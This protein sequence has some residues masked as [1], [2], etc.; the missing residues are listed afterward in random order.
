MSKGFFI[1][2]EGGEGAGKSTV[3][4][5]L[6]EKLT[7]KG[8]TVIASREPGGCSLAEELRS[9]LLHQ[10]KPI[11]AKCELFLFLAARVQHIEEVIVPALDRGAIVLCDRFSD[12]TIAYQGCGKNLGFEYVQQVCKLAEGSCEPDCTLFLDI[13]PERGLKRTDTRRKENNDKTGPDRMEQESLS[14]HAR[15]RAGFQKLAGLYSERIHTIDASLD[16]H[17]VQTK[18]LTIIEK[19]LVL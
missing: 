16:L 13:D 5:F 15:V 12:S 9:L 8:H 7:Q 3:M 18:A 17:N 2:L 6:K 19:C 10:T 4:T 11:A 1:T 14:F